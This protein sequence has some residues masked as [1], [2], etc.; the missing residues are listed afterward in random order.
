VSGPGRVCLVCR[1][2]VPGDLPCDPPEHEVVALS[3]TGR[4]RLVEAAWGDRRQQLALM[5]AGEVRN[6]RAAAAGVVTG[7]AAGAGIAVFLGPYRPLIL[8]GGVLAGGIAAALTGAVHGRDQDARFPRAA[9]ALPAPAPF[10]RGVI[11]DAGDDLRSPASGLWCAA[12]AIELTL[13]RPGGPRVVFRDAAA[14]GLE[15]HLDGGARARVPAGP[16][17]P[18]GALVPLLDVDEHALLAHLR[19]V[20]PRHRD[21]DP[22]AP[23]QHDA[24]HE[25]LLMVG[26]RVELHGAWTPVPDDRRGA[27]PL[28]RDAPPTLLVPAGWPS[29]RRAPA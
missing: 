16:W 29:L 24:V 23:F 26:E 10:A 9:A 4:A 28:Y 12:W 14:A 7:V 18:A 25:S 22:V 13:A 11:V 2:A 27:E 8:A 19:D 3:D 5:R 21:D 6:R 15:I 17:R 20:D 1:H